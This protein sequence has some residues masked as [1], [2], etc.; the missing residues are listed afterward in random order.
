MLEDDDDSQEAILKEFDEFVAMMREHIIENNSKSFIMFAVSADV[1]NEDEDDDEDSVFTFNGFR[2]W[3]GNHD[4]VLGMHL[5]SMFNTTIGEF[6]SD[7]ASGE[8]ELREEFE[9]NIREEIA[10]SLMEDVPPEIANMIN[11]VFEEYKKRHSDQP[12]DLNSLRIL[13]TGNDTWN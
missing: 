6:L 11:E 1:E 9:D 13:K 3:A 8:Q 2:H 5:G 4:P 10:N 7:V 12:I